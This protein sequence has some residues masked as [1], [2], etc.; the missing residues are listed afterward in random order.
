MGRAILEK[1][2]S[3]K[4]EASQPAN[5]SLSLAGFAVHHLAGILRLDGRCTAGE[6]RERAG[7][8]LRKEMMGR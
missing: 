6:V 3:V 5:E 8:N 2:V 7:T 1:T 4:A